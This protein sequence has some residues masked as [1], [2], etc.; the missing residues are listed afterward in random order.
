MLASPRPGEDTNSTNQPRLQSSISPG[1]RRGDLGDSKQQS[2]H[3]LLDDTDRQLFKRELTTLYH[4][5]VPLQP[6]TITNIL[7]HL[8]V[9]V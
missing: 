8:S 5:L 1:S 9:N 3:D 2:L 4:V 6:P 7:Y